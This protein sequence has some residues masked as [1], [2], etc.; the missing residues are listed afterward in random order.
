MNPTILV[1]L[2]APRPGFV[3]TRLAAELGAQRATEIYRAL[4]ETQLRR[5]PTAWRTEIHFAPA[6][7]AEEMRA[8]LGSPHVFRAQS[9]G[10]LGARLAAG[11]AAA[12]TES[13]A[14]VI[15]IGGDC[16]ELDAA[17]LERAADALRRA[18]L[19]LGPAN[20]GGYYLIGLNRP[21]PQLFEQIEWSSPRVLTQTLARA[22]QSELRCELLETKTDIDDAAS[23]A[24]F[25]RRRN[26]TSSAGKITVVIPALN[27]AAQIETTIRSTLRCLCGARIIVADGGSTDGTSALAKTAGAEVTLSARGRGVQ[28]AAAADLVV[29]EWLLFLHADTLLPVHALQVIEPFIVRGDARIA[30]FRLRFDTA[31]RFL[32]VCCWFTRFDS[33]FTRFG[34]QGILMR[35]DFY[36]EL[37]G[38]PAWPLF[39]DVALLQRARRQTRVWSLPAAVTT[40]ARRFDRRGHISQQWL[41][42][43]LLFCYLAGA[44]P[45][46]LA[47]IYRVSLLRRRVSTALPVPVLNEAERSKR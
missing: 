19:V 29:T 3:K 44:S 40:S 36:R 6:D 38:F 25:E 14:P 20:D 15:A 17:C 39:E 22:A 4:A 30:T 34:D 13:A 9:G 11:F 35:R 27:E 43:R 23:W 5:I 32:R 2:K 16:P 7:A 45:E 33:V 46:R 21:T 24:E 37:G 47:E 18:D 28:L 1:F 41:N 12:F 31:G 42:A 10:D 26:A 8:W